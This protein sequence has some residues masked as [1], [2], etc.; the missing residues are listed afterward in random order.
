MNNH[1][2]INVAQKMSMSPPPPPRRRASIEELRQHH[3]QN[4]SLT[5]PYFP[6]LAAVATHPTQHWPQPRQSQPQQQQRK[7]NIFES[8]QSNQLMRTPHLQPRRLSPSSSPPPSLSSSLHP[9]ESEEENPIFFASPQPIFLENMKECPFGP[10]N[11]RHQLRAATSLPFSHHSA[12]MALSSPPSITAP[13]VQATALTLAPSPPSFHAF[14][15]MSISNKMS[16]DVDD[17]DEQLEDNS[18]GGSSSSTRSSEGMPKRRRRASLLDEYHHPPSNMNRSPL[19]SRS[20]G[21]NR[22]SFPR[23]A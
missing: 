12:T 19:S 22:Q 3:D 15:S 21:G 10:L 18:S 17:D 8:Q 23:A 1:A 4:K 20:G 14:N 5:M 16:F 11:R 13:S 9:L 7:R 6:K 2:Y